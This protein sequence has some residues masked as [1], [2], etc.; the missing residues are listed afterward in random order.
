MVDV[1]EVV[2]Y[3]GDV[4]CDECFGVGVCDGDED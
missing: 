4:D 2:V 1:F 3:C